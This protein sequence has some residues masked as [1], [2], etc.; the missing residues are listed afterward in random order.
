MSEKS[1]LVSNNILS[2]FFILLGA[3]FVLPSLNTILLLQSCR[4]WPTTAGTVISSEIE[5]FWPDAK[6][7]V[8][9]QY[10]PLVW[11]SYS[12]KDQQ[13]FSQSLR[14]VQPYSGDVRL[15]QES[16]KRYPVGQQIAVK[17]N[18]DDPSI[19]I[20]ERSA[21]P[22]WDCVLLGMGMLFVMIGS[23]ALLGMIFRKKEEALVECSD[24]DIT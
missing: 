10:R 6:P 8:A 14:F 13:Y 4:E 15:A 21:I 9:N 20:V 22:K 19:A 18:P 11:F 7:S 1:P 24:S 2:V 23:I 5:T 12:V 16:L 17:Y 3:F